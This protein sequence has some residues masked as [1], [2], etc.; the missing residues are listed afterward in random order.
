MSHL[1]ACPLGRAQARSLGW[2]T[3][4]ALTSEPSGVVATSKQGTWSTRTGDPAAPME[5]ENRSA[6]SSRQTRQSLSPPPGPL[7]RHRELHSHAFGEP[8]LESLETLAT[9]SELPVADPRQPSLGPGLQGLDEWLPSV[10]LEFRLCT[11]S[12]GHSLNVVTLQHT[13]PSATT[14][15]DPHPSS[16]CR[17]H[18]CDSGGH[19][20]I[21]IYT[22]Q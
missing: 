9:R 5:S 12:P 17:G 2:R 18:T 8:H 4:L 16:T 10:V 14:D 19:A 7:S 1:L 13:K 3:Q 20:Q 6:L 21:H 11:P 15:A 22:H